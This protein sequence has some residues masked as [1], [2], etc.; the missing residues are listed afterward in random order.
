MRTGGRGP[1]V[2]CG[3]ARADS[4]HRQGSGYWPAR[5]VDQFTQ[6]YRARGHRVLVV[7][8]SY[9]NIEPDEPGVARVPAIQ[10]FNGSDFSVILPIPLYLTRSI[11][12]FQ[13]DLFH[14]HHPFLL[15]DTA[16]RMASIHQVPL[17]FTYH[18]MYELYTHYVP[19]GAVSL[20]EMAKRLSVGYANLC[21]HVI[22]PSR[23]I[24]GLIAARGVSTPITVIPTGVDPARYERGEGNR[25]RRGLG[26]PEKAFVV[27]HVGRLAP[28]KN[29]N[30]LAEA[31]GMFLQRDQSAHLVV[32]GAGPSQSGLMKCLDG[33]G[34]GAR[35]HF[36]GQLDE[37]D[38]IDA[39]HAMD[40]FAFSS[41]SETQGIVVVEAMAA[42]VPVVALDAPAVSEV[43]EDGLNGLVVSRADP[44]EFAEALER[45]AGLPP[46]RRDAFRQAAR[47][48]A[49]KYSV[50]VSAERCLALYSDVLSGA[51]CDISQQI[52]EWSGFLNRVGEEWNLWA[53][54]LSALAGVVPRTGVEQGGP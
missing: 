5:S 32:V 15:G 45:V 18:T 7:A 40:V 54:R 51:R 53:N 49:R 29:L 34:V 44:R 14:S 17:V 6:A 50:D 37:P 28:E 4:A 33:A 11:N 39:Y 13:P 38:V 24:A 36:T 46:Q 52:Y 27:G 12:E 3:G 41:R 19:F 43:V 30:F 22:A 25:F 35:A 42:G 48:T 9:E 1:D 47:G 16:L 31:T 8:P 26:I 21:A 2:D 10:R 20:G 23:Y